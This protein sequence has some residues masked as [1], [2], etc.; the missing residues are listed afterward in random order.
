[1]RSIVDFAKG[2]ILIALA[3]ALLF[4]SGVRSCLFPFLAALLLAHWADRPVSRLAQQLPRWLAALLILTISGLL[5]CCLLLLL[6]VKL[7][8]D[9]PAVLAGARDGTALWTHLE[10]F[11]ARLPAF[12]RGGIEWL[13]TQLQT[14]SSALRTHL[15]EALTEWAAST[16]A[17]L[18]GILFAWGVALLGSFYAAADWQRVKE[19]L[20]RLLPHGWENAIRS[21]FH[22][23]M[24]GALGWLRVQGRLM[25]IT[26]G[27]LV[28]G[29]L[30]MDIDGALTLAL[31]IA[32]ADAL[33]VFGSGLL[34]VPWAALTLIQ[35]QLWRALGLMFLWMIAA[36][37]R[38]VLEP[39]FLGRQAGTSPLVTLLVMYIGLRLFGIGGLILAPIALSAGMAVIEG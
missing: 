5:L 29:F 18:P 8:Q 1:M 2:G 22:K 17:A 28:L 27:L 26:F 6:I 37:C 21:L 31:F 24:Q 7:W 39:R 14:Q 25:L 19:G 32:L 12:L 13:L 10:H 16:A 11:A 3:L 33:P 36:L 15:T 20:L 23:L 35:G 30:V 34:L 38:S 4:S 9:V